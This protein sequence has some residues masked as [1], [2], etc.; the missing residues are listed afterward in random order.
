VG[1]D[2][3]GLGLPGIGRV[4]LGFL[5]TAGLAVG[6]AYA[7]KRWWPGALLARR[8]LGAQIRTISRTAVTRTLVVH[9]VEVDGARVVI[10]E[11]RTGVG[12]SVI[13]GGTSAPAASTAESGS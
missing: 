8:P 5:L 12:V 13:P 7:L 10:A 4:V 2:I 3:E 9:L 6:I 1:G 11:G